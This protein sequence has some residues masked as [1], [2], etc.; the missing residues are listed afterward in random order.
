MIERVLQGRIDEFNPRSSLEQENILT[1]SLQHFALVYL[2]R[3]GFFKEA[4]FH[5]GTCL[6]VIHGMQRF[7]E[8]G[9]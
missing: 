5:G 1:E 4:M 6:R 8:V 9:I 2:S 7:L 3:T